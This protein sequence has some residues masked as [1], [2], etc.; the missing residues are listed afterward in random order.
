MFK[1]NRKDQYLKRH[2]GTQQFPF[3]PRQQIPVDRGFENPEGRS[4][5]EKIISVTT[6]SSARL[7]ERI[8]SLYD[9]FDLLINS[10]SLQFRFKS[11]Y[12]KTST[13]FHTVQQIK[14]EWW[15]CDKTYIGVV[16]L[17]QNYHK[18]SQE[19]IVWW[20]CV[21]T[22]MGTTKS[23]SLLSL[24]S[25]FA[26]PNKTMFSWI[27]DENWKKTSQVSG[28]ENN[29]THWDSTSVFVSMSFIALYSLHIAFE[30]QLTPPPL[31]STIV[32][33]WSSQQRTQSLR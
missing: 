30:P 3:L 23:I 22:Y 25:T 33:I 7:Q 6:G 29:E 20:T 32:I 21:K 1:I 14:R 13:L 27:Q 16:S 24:A 15:C 2:G 18:C 11:G 26:N 17:C 28:T 8:C 19:I 31:N 10:Y 12:M 9:R 5:E 4:V